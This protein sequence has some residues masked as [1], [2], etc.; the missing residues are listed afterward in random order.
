MAGGGLELKG[1]LFPHERSL[2]GSNLNKDGLVCTFIYSLLQNMNE[3]LRCTKC[4]GGGQGIKKSKKIKTHVLS[5]SEEFT[6]WWG[7]GGT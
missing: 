1:S 2:P 3:G 4:W 7:W 5:A 6:Q